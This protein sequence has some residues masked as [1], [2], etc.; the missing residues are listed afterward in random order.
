MSATVTRGA[1][2]SKELLGV[3]RSGSACSA[4]AA[5]S[6]AMVLKAW[7]T[8]N[9]LIGMIQIMTQWVSKPLVPKEALCSGPDCYH[10]YSMSNVLLEGELPKL[11]RHTFLILHHCAVHVI[12]DISL[13]VRL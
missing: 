7:D 4:I 2:S 11:R 13:E 6:C 5:L 1:P 10:L 3:K 9:V 12:A 8:V